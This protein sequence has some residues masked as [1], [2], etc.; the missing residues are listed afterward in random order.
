[1]A[2]TLPAAPGKEVSVAVPEEVRGPLTVK[3]RLRYRK[4]D[5]TLIE[6]LYPGKGI[7]APVTDMASC[8]VQIAVTSP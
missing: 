1:M 2:R 7:T 3:A 8:A 6:Y 5:Q 4:V